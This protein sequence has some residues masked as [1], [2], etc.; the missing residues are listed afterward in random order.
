MSEPHEL[1][2]DLVEY[3]FG[4]PSEQDRLTVEAHLAACA[5]CRE[6]VDSL[7]EMQTQLSAV[8][9]EAM[10]DGPPPDAD[11]LLQRALR[12]V[13]KESAGVRTRNRTFAA[14]A[15]VVVAAAAIGVGVLV[16]RTTAGTS[17]PIAAPPPASVRPT[18]ARFA[19]GTDAATGARLT[20]GVTPA[21]GWVRVNA[22]V[23]GIPAGQRCRVVVV[24]KDGAREVAGSWLVS[25]KAAN[26][27]V[28][29]DGSALIDPAN[30]AAVLVENTDGKQFV[31][32]KV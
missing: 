32:V 12:Q 2:V 31:Q 19:S 28:N 14:A 4:E 9:P 24:G 5:Q 26:E 7:T 17:S 1:H 22:S 15:A 25:P 27:G 29:L 21:A 10:L 18:G 30:V 13:R 16:G 3:L 6:E 8:P 23:T 20:V 11:L